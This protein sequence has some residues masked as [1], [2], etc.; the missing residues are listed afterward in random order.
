M[1]TAHRLCKCSLFPPPYL[2]HTLFLSPLLYKALRRTQVAVCLGCAGRQATRP[3][4]SGHHPGGPGARDRTERTAAARYY[5]AGPTECTGAA[6]AGCRSTPW[7]RCNAGLPARYRLWRGLAATGH[8]GGRLSV[9]SASQPGPK[10][11]SVFPAA[12]QPQWRPCAAAGTPHPPSTSTA[13]FSPLF[14]SKP[15][16]CHLCSVLSTCR[17]AAQ[18]R[19]LCS[20]LDNSS[21]IVVDTQWFHVLICHHVIRAAESLQCFWRCMYGYAWSSLVNNVS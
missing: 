15:L 19:G 9:A 2:T 4:H 18:Y 14:T 10:R 6:H 16:S 3:D 11:W 1:H 12:T 7:Q 20:L 5:G 8:G 17:L 13:I 21:G